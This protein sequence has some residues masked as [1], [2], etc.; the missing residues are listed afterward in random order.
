MA[1][2]AFFFKVFVY[3]CLVIPTPNVR[4][5]FPDWVSQVPLIRP[6]HLELQ[7]MISKT[8]PASESS[9]YGRGWELQ[10]C[11]KEIQDIFLRV[12]FIYEAHCITLIAYLAQLGG[13]GTD[14]SSGGDLKPSSEAR[15]WIHQDHISVYLSRH[16][17]SPLKNQISSYLSLLHVLY[18]QDESR[19]HCWWC[20]YVVNCQSPSN[21]VKERDTAKTIGRE[22]SSLYI[23]QGCLASSCT[24]HSPLFSSSLDFLP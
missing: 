23:G 7:W 8:V 17:P 14:G 2:L 13:A 11:W 20:T 4:L 3:W 22:N 19:S 12:I 5:E 16:C 10:S 15:P 1:D 9:I 18:R 6:F 21:M 24:P